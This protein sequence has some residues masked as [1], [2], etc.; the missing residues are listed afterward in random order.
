[1]YEAVTRAMLG[2]YEVF[3]CQGLALGNLGRHE[4]ALTAFTTAASLEPTFDKAHD[5]RDAAL[6]NLGRSEETV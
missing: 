1:M 3:F 5:H 4:E 6:Y 2:F